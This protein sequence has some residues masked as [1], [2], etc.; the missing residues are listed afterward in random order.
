M[1]FG[2]ITITLHD[3]Y[4]I[5]RL[6]IVGH[7]LSSIS[8]SKPYIAVL[9]GLLELTIDQVQSRFFHS[10][11]FS[12]VSLLEHMEEG[13]IPYDPMR[14]RC[15]CNV[16]SGLCFSVTPQA[17]TLRSGS[18]AVLIMCTRLIHMHGGCYTCT[19]V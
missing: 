10:G 3:V 18:L 1:S 13:N 6:P 9:A 19:H 12:I 2:E 11:G 4:Y 5:L 7:D 15:T 16:C 17:P 8:D 14:R